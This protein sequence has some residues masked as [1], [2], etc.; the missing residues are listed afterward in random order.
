VFL[1]M[2]PHKRSS[3]F[4]TVRTRKRTVSGSY[5]GQI[6]IAGVQAADR[7][8]ETAWFFWDGPTDAFSIA[9]VT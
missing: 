1:D 2:A 8:S 6:M 4:T 7:G 5:R 9:T 3:A